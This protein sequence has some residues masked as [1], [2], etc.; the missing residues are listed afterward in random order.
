MQKPSMTIY[1]DINPQELCSRKLW[2]LVNTPTEVSIS[3]RALDDVIS[4]PVLAG[5]VTEP[6]GVVCPVAV[7]VNGPVLASLDSGPAVIHAE[8]AEDVLVGGATARED[9]VDAV[10]GD[11]GLVIIAAVRYKRLGYSYTRVCQP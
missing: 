10:R 11:P 7:E 1:N 8:L 3:K 6:V 9:G 5:G 4:E 2:Q